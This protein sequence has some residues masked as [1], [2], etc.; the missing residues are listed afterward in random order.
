VIAALDTASATASFALADSATGEC[1]AVDHDIALG[2]RSAGLLD[3]V[4]EMLGDREIGDIRQWSIGMGPGSFTGI[5]VGAAMVKGICQGTGAAYR[6]LPSSLG[7]IV[8]AG[9]TDGGQVLALS[10][11]RRGQ[12]LV[13][14]YRWQNSSAQPDGDATVMDLNALADSAAIRFVVLAT[15]PIADSVTDIVGD[16]ACILPHADASCLLAPV[17]W[18]WPTAAAREDSTEPIYVRPPV[19]VPPRPARIQ[20]S[21]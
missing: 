7:L 5:R 16:R 19:F 11:G 14:P 18:D 21:A 9:G 2:R 15:D 13:S 6:G 17:G 10:D 20:V 4:L 12:V 3:R 1:L 8:G